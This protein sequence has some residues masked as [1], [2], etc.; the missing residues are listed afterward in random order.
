M[1]NVTL[2]NKRVW[3]YGISAAGRILV[4]YFLESDIT[5]MGIIDN[6]YRYVDSSFM[7]VSIL[8]L[9]KS[10]DL[11]KEEDVI[12][13]AMTSERYVAEKSELN[14]YGFMNIMHYSEIN[15]GEWINVFLEDKETNEI[16]SKI[17]DSEDFRKEAIKGYVEK[18]KPLH[19][20]GKDFF[21]H[22]KLWE[23]AY[24]T[25]V[26]E[27][28]GMLVEGKRGIGFAVGKEP[29][30]SYFA[31]CD[32]NI[33]A[34][35]LGIDTE[36]GRAWNACDGNA[37]SNKWNIYYNEICNREKFIKNVSYVDFDMNDD[38][39]KLGSYDFCWSSCAIEHLG[40]LEKSISFLKRAAKMLK[41]GGISVH[42]TEINLLSNQDTIDWG[43]CVMFRK[44]DIEELEQ[45]FNAEGY[46]MKCFWGRKRTPQ[47]EYVDIP[48]YNGGKERWHLS[49]VNASG[50]AQTSYAIIIKRKM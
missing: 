24:I 12:I 6:D 23:W 40:S 20:E 1:K 14:Q 22:R 31:N 2:K 27:Q 13:C 3:I 44:K 30:S 4:R 28:T 42:T 43:Y 29:L 9:C 15:M 16:V 5:I 37:G 41:P 33:C 32:V 48:P 18:Y 46:E 34:T 39:T 25:Y 50:V 49:L 38:L 11:I 47:N 36:I 8:P 19:V 21:W 35:D 45:Y 10:R 17:C 7:G 26:L